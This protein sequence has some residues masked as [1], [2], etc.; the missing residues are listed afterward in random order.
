M[1]RSMKNLCWVLLLVVA[2]PVAA[3]AGMGGGKMLKPGV[4]APDFEFTDIVGEKGSIHAFAPGKPF[5]LVFL[6]TAC[7]S[8]QRE[9]AYLK[10]LNEQGDDIEVLSVFL[11]M[12]ERDFIGH[13]KGQ[14]LTFRFFWDAEYKI[15]DAYGVSFTPSSFLI[16][17][18]RKIAN[19][20][21]GWSRKGHT[22]EGDLKKLT[23]K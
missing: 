23:E 3:F 12:R 1:K 9:M 17:S 8:C 22:L 15:A 13:V 2:L 19:V 16:D 5:L 4:V 18:D 14:G 21:R 7:R 11:D 20:Y 10:E 6:Q